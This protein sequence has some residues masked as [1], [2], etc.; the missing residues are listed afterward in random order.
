M[1]PFCDVIFLLDGVRQLTALD[2]I[3][4]F[5]LRELG[6]KSEDPEMLALM[7]DLAVREKKRI[8][9]ELKYEIHC[10]KARHQHLD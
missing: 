6:S 5:G 8:T 10:F 4:D 1:I 2:K 9:D 3:I 7:M